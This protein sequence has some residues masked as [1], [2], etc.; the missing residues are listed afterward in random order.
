[1]KN[2]L[3]TFFTFRTNLD[4]RKH[5]SLPFLFVLI[6]EFLHLLFL[7]WR[8][9]FPWC[10]FAG[11]KEKVLVDRGHQI[12]TLDRFSGIW[13]SII[14]NFGRKKSLMYK[15]LYKFWQFERVFQKATF[16]SQI[17]SFEAPMSWY[18]NSIFVRLKKMMIKTDKEQSEEK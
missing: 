10:Q 14:T 7:A 16:S 4:G 6:L 3:R 9:S 15:Y 1:M 5:V 18:W 13:K 11:K 8:L 12:L 2:R 17:F